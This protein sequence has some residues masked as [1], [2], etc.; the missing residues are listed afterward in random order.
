MRIAIFSDTFPPQ[1]DGVSSVASQL[2]QTLSEKGHE[3]CV[4]TVSRY[5]RKDRPQTLTPEFEVIRLP[6]VP[7]LVYSGHRLA[8]PT[9]RTIRQ[10]KKFRP[11]VIH[12]HTPF[13]VGWGAKQAAKKLGIPLVGTHHTFY[14]HYMKHIKM[15]FPRMKK[16]SWKFVIGYYNHCDLVLS[17]T[18]SLADTL[19]THGLKSPIEVV[20]NPIDTELFRPA[21]ERE[22][23]LEMKKKLG[24]S[25]SGKAIVYMGRVSYE[26][27]IEK[28]IEAFALVAKKMP[29]IKLIIVGDGPESEKLKALAERLGIKD[30]VIFTGFLKKGE[31]VS[32]LHA[33]EMFVTASKSENMP[34][35]VLEAMACGLPIIAVRALGIP[36]IVKNGVNGLLSIPDRPQEMAQ[37]IIRL[38]ED[39]D[40]RKKF[41]AASRQFS[42]N[43]SRKYIAELHEAAYRKVLDMK[44]NPR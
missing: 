31:L 11:D 29:E 44:Y 39:E 13:S 37:N 15:D 35:S 19:K 2:A 27:S 24:I 17:P 34:I 33:A 43:Y 22:S 6:S 14:D 1:I 9:G 10:M 4:V 20:P 7:A 26:K 25:G 16:L 21:T 8:L 42:L 40:L 38:L 18:C 28:A 5:K 41:S 30:K 3:I 36:E 12:V 23:V 32:A